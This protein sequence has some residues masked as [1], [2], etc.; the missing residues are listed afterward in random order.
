MRDQIIY[1][2][3]T[4][5]CCQFMYKGWQIRLT[6][7]PPQE[8]AVFKN[9]EDLLPFKTFKAV[10]EAIDWVHNRV[11]NKVNNKRRYSAWHYTEPGVE[12]QQEVEE[13]IAKRD[14][15]DEWRVV[16]TEDTFGDRRDVEEAMLDEREQKVQQRIREAIDAERQRIIH[17]I[18]G[19]KL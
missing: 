16:A 6:T 10:A 12:T 4:H 17:N 11:N 13:W 1:V 7:V 14:H 9:V 3:N 8:V 18:I 19:V 15:P 5:H 2:Q